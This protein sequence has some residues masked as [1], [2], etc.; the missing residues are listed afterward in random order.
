MKLNFPHPKPP[1]PLV[2][3]LPGP[4]INCKGVLD[5][6]LRLLRECNAHIISV[7]GEPERISS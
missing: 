6:I 4:L 3:I 7:A 2:N 5:V 1:V